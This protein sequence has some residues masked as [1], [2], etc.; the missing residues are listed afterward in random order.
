MRTSITPYPLLAREFSV[1]TGGA[2]HPLVV[3]MVTNMSV[4]LFMYGGGRVDQGGLR[5]GYVYERLLHKR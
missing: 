2:K 1:V 5:G 3:G 4:V